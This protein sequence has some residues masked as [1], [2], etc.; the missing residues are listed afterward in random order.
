VPHLSAWTVA[1]LDQQFLF[2]QKFGQ[3]RHDKC[4]LFHKLVNGC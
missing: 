1:S 3:L 2:P 4:C